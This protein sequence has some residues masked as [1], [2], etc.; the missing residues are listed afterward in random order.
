MERDQLHKV[1]EKEAWI[2]HEEFAL[3]GSEQRLNEVLDRHLSN[4]GKRSDDE[5]VVDLGDGKTGRV[6]LMLHKVTQPRTGYFDY[7]IV[8]LKRPSQRIDEDVINQVKKYA[9]AVARDERF[10]G[11]PARWTFIAVSNSMNEFAKR[12]ANQ[13]GRPKGQV[14]DDAEL[15]I[16]VWVRTWAE[17]LN[18]AR[19]RLR[20]VNEHLAYEADSDSAKQYLRKTH[21]KYI[22]VVDA[23]VDSET[24]SD[25][26]TS[27]TQ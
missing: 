21:D 22:P 10:Q 2:F 11:V 14:F 4:L 23:S 24:A 16:T 27:T 5:A 26:A 12:D 9:V 19:A 8:E 3:A 7:L 17:V 13:R 6:D 15:N 20:F 25:A 18:D 1:L